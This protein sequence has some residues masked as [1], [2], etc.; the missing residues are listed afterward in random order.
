MG[1]VGFR[2]S[3]DNPGVWLMHCHIDWHFVIGLSVHFVEVEDVLHEEGLAAF[4]SNMMLSVCN[5]DG[6]YTL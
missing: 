3:A 2:M 1:Y 4:S 5:R 6:N